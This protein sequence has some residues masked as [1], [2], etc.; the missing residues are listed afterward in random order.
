[1]DKEKYYWLKLF[2]DFFTNPRIKKLRRIPGGDTYVVIYLKLALLSIKNNA[3]IEYE[4]IAETLAGEL[5]LRIDET[6][7]SIEVTLS[8]LK[9]HGMLIQLDDTL[10]HLP[11]IARCAGSETRAAAR[12]REQRE[13]NRL[14]EKKALDKIGM[15]TVCDIVPQMSQVCPADVPPRKEER[16]SA[17]KER[18]KEYKKEDYV[19]QKR[20]GQ[21]TGTSL[22]SIRGGSFEMRMTDRLI[23][24]CLR[25][26]PHQK[27]IPAT[28]LQKQTWALE[29]ARL[30][31]D[32]YSE[33]DIEKTLDF[34]T[35]NEFW[36]VHI[37]SSRK[38]R[39]KFE[40]LYLKAVS[41]HKEKSQGKNVKN[42]FNSMENHRYNIS[43]LE[44]ALLGRTKTDDISSIYDTGNDS[45]SKKPESFVD[46]QSMK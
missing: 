35:T 10:C 42:K 25:D 46:G 27:N 1:M 33:G 22:T 30:K 40:Q 43:E 45:G 20:T 7:E 24:S 17:Q 19:L 29:F 31:T 13:R 28:E 15:I 32:G 36:K 4:G 5:S 37:R 12:K 34:A 16:K 44:K 39:E 11:E 9:S 23:K 2:E 26:L 6:E 14:E 41:S 18:I 21:E 8:Y 3:N 38:F